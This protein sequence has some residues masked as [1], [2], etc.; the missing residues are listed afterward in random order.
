MSNIC[1]EPTNE[2][3]MEQFAKLR[4]DVAAIKVSLDRISPAVE[5]AVQVIQGNGLPGH[6]E[7]ARR[8]IAHELSHAENRRL[9]LGTIVKAG[10]AILVIAVQIWLGTMVQQGK[11][12]RED[13]ATAIAAIKAQITMLSN[14][15]EKK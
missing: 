2:R 3:C 15:I 11:M 9:G 4:E 10:G 8:V 12:Q 1:T 5:R 13:A 7:I 6:Q 14:E